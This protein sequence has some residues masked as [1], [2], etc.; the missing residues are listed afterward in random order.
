MHTFKPNSSSLLSS[1]PPN[2]PLPSP[3][4]PAYKPPHTKPPSP[5]R[6]SIPTSTSVSAASRGIDPSSSAAAARAYTDYYL[7]AFTSN[8]CECI[9]TAA[10][11][12]KALLQQTHMRALTEGTT[13]HTSPKLL[14]L[15]PPRFHVYWQVSLKCPVAP[16]L[17]A[18][19][20]VQWHLMLPPA[21]MSMCATLLLPLPLL[22]QNILLLL[23]PKFAQH[24]PHVLVVASD[25]ASASLV[26]T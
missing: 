18:S 3:P 14:P 15:A 16:A 4:P 11:S 9:A 20:L 10:R 13:S 25:A 17:F 6:C 21:L 26:L 5:L 19:A 7:A 8:V 12:N 23:L 22:L 2:K 24:S 1:R